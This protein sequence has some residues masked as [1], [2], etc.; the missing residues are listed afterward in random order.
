MIPIFIARIYDNT[1]SFFGHTSKAFLADM[2]MDGLGEYGGGFVI[3][4]S[5]L[6]YHQHHC[7]VLT[8][9][10]GLRLGMNVRTYIWRQGRQGLGI[11]WQVLIGIRAWE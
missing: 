2:G 6:V 9:F 3:S 8:S 11:R 5:R 10:F 1:S 7:S 4:T